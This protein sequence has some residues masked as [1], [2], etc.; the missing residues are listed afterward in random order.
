M[1][2]SDLLGSSRRAQAPQRNSDSKQ[3]Q[4]EPMTMRGPAGSR[5]KVGNMRA[6]PGSVPAAPH[7]AC[8]AHSA[9]SS[10]SRCCC[11]SY[12][13]VL[14]NKSRAHVHLASVP[15]N[16]SLFL[17]LLFIEVVDL[18]PSPS[19]P[20]FYNPPASTS[21]ILELELVPSCLA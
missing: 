10:L 13:S 20:G 11:F 18:L 6:V 17:F 2:R 3:K 9:G 1:T 4:K 5:D 7:L 21:R 14:R 12:F 16:Q 15:H 19:W 8:R